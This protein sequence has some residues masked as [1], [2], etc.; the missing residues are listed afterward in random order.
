[1]SVLPYVFGSGTIVA[2][3][4][5]PN[6]AG[7][8]T[9]LQLG[10]MQEC[11]VE[12]SAS[13]K[14]LYGKLQFPVAI[15]RTAGKLNMKAKFAT[16]YAKVLNDLFFGATVGTGGQQI[17]QINE[18]HA[19]AATITITPPN[20]GTFV[21]DQGV[22]RSDT[23][24]NMP[25]S[26]TS[27]PAAGF[28]YQTNGTYSFNASDVTAGFG[29]QISYIWSG[30]NLNGTAGS[31]SNVTNKP[32]GSQ[33]TFEAWLTNSQFGMNVALRFPYC[34]SSKLTLSMK[35]E[36]FTIPEFDFSA[37]SDP[38]GNLFYEYLDE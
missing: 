21:K 3:P 2:T 25:L 11:S 28:Y 37:F 17:A 29:V 13:Q 30:N 7:N 24:I 22:I 8:P 16:I 26:P 1:M 34:I 36:D 4:F 19:I 27:N 31:N 33:P 38:S 9:P 12:F 23:G 32:M 20:S 14:E 18:A 35:N 15:A 10:T 5:G 6:A